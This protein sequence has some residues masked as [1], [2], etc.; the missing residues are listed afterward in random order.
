MPSAKNPRVPESEVV[1]LWQQQL[2]KDRKLLDAGGE[3]L[4]VIYPGRSNDS[5]GGDFRDAVISRGNSTQ[6]GCIEVHTVTSGW[7]SHGHHRDP[8]YN[9]VILHVAMEPVAGKP[10]CTRL[11]NGRVIPTVILEKNGTGKSVSGAGGL[12][13]QGLGRRWSTERLGESLDLAGDRRLALKAG[14]FEQD[15]AVIEPGQVL[16][17][18]FS[19]A[20]GYSRNKQPFLSL[21]CAASLKQVQE[22]LRDAGS[23][24]PALY[25]LQAFLL[26]RAGLLPSQRS[27][28]TGG[29]PFPARLEQIWRSFPQMEF[30]P[31]LGW[32]LFKVRP[33]NYPVRRIAALSSLLYRFRL[34]GWLNTLLDLIRRAPPA[35]AEKTLEPALT[36]IAEEYWDKHYDFGL[37][38]P[39]GLGCCLLGR[40]RSAEIVINVLLPFALAWSAFS[41]DTAPGRQ[42]RL[43]HQRYRRLESNSVERHMLSQLSISS[44]LAA[45]ARR[46]QGLLHIYQTLCTRGRCADCEYTG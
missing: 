1:R 14:R 3:P 6:T 18:G 26:G 15:L 45:T 16:Y 41:G 39:A 8:A 40:E 30:N 42:A 11:E 29:H 23:G 34:K 43:I 44:R 22:I 17:K 7:Q 32:E 35:R 25:Y 28:E 4:E 31:A 37:G 13:C 5:R 38:N 9:Q 21:A 36:V 46:Q 27:L 2:Q 33:G 24:N 10:V 12:P 19:E 20:L